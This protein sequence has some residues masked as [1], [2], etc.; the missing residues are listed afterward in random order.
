MTSV[1]TNRSCTD[2]NNSNNA[3]CIIGCRLQQHTNYRSDKLDDCNIISTNKNKSQ[4]TISTG[5]GDVRQPKTNNNVYD[6]EVYN[7]GFGFTATHIDMTQENYTFQD[8]LSESMTKHIT[9]I[10]QFD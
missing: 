1:S 9:N 5:S 10:S 7:R 6:A 2:E 8:D 3:S 4:N